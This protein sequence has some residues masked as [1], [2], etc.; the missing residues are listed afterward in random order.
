MRTKAWARS[1]SALVAFAAWA[2]IGRAAPAR[3]ATALP[4]PVIVI[5]ASTESATQ[6]CAADTSGGVALQQATGIAPCLL[7]NSWGYDADAI[8]VKDGCAGTFVLGQG[9]T[10]P[11]AAA[12]PT[13]IQTWGA[14][15]PGKGFLVGK[16]RLGDL[17]ISAYALV[18][19][20]NQMPAGQTFTDHLGNVHPVDARNDI[21]AHRIMIHLKGWMGLP[22]FL[23]QITIWTVNPT[24]QKAVFAVLGYQF[25][26]AF[27]LYAGLNGLPGSRTLLGSHPYWLGHDRVMAD[28][29]FRPYFTHGVWASGEV[30]PG[31]WYTGMIGN[32]LSALGITAGQLTRNFALS[33]TVWWMPTTHEFGPNGGFD[34]YEWH[35]ELATRFGIAYTHSLENRFTADAAEAPDNTTLRLADSL[36]VF[37]PG[38]FAPGVTVTDARYRMLE[39][40]AGLKYHGIFV[41]TAY[42]ARWLDDFRATGPI[43]IHSLVDQ[44]FYVQAAFYPVKQRLELYGATS[45][46]F[47]DQSE[48]F[49]ISHEYL[50]GANWFFA[51]TRD[52]RVNA[53]LIRIVRSPVSS[54]FGYYIGGQTGMTAALAVSMLF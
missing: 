25:H 21:W 10:A 1:A 40:D 4:A 35:E 31:L 37:D 15:E 22:K 52:L 8:W 3:S 26:R 45:W 17:Y 27:S 36:N 18:R 33:G 23:Y 47:P 24:D 5:C 41:G 9:A 20:L 50:G 54:S 44:G 16:T 28:E 11:P 48:G 2:S 32:N 43:P 14:V 13:P 34:D 29:F 49:E 7:G 6:R 12:E 46:V 39:A 51:S 30:L 19:Y 53:Q 42:F 38:S